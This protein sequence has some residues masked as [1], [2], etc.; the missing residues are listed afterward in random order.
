MFV[1]PQ[2][3]RAFRNGFAHGFFLVRSRIFCAKIPLYKTRHCIKGHQ[4]FVAEVVVK[5]SV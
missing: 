1:K 3:A 5:S 4:G 2:K